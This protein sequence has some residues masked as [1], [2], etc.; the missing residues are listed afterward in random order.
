M[1]FTVQNPRAFECS[2][3]FSP[4]EHLPLQPPSLGG[5]V[6]FPTVLPS[7]PLAGPHACSTAAVAQQVLRGLAPGLG[8][9]AAGKARGMQP[10]GLSDS[11]ADAVAAACGAVCEQ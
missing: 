4:S 6:P 9:A 8:T 3:S 2:L 7:N 11:L 1:H 5:T 10:L